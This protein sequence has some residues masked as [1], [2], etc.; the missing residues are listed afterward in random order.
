M[1]NNLV[2]TIFK[3][4]AVGMGIAV[5]VLG[6][7][8]TLVPATADMLLGIGLAALAISSFQKEGAHNEKDL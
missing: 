8:G 5:I 7:L 2:G 1:K 4:I 6:V 3:A